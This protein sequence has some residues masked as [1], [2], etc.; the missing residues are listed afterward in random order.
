MFCEAASGFYDSVASEARTRHLPA[1]AIAALARLGFS[2][3]VSE[4][5]FREVKEP[6]DFNAVADL[7]L[8]AL[9]DAFDARAGA[10]LLL[11]APLAPRPTGKCVPVG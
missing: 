5:N 11:E 8:Q 6:P 3:D 7:I 2:T 1:S 10:T 4:G 9:H